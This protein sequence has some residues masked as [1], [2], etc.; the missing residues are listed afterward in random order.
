[1][2]HGA[3]CIYGC[4]VVARRGR[5]GPVGRAGRQVV[6]FTISRFTLAFSFFVTA[7]LLTLVSSSC[8]LLR[9]LSLV[10]SK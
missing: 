2:V 4:V 6:D 9:M 7:Q 5:H 1:M 3:V 8:F 10:G